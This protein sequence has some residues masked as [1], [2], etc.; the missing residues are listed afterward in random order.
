MADT[1]ARTFFDFYAVNAA[2]E[3]AMAESQYIAALSEITGY[4]RMVHAS[5][6]RIAELET[7]VIT[8]RRRVRQMMGLE[9]WSGESPVENDQS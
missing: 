6:D 9:S 1:V 5:F 8:L 3:L 4:R 2:Q 7:E